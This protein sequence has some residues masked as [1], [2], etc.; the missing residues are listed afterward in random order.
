MQ[1]VWTFSEDPVQECDYYHYWSDNNRTAKSFR[2]HLWNE[3]VGNVLWEVVLSHCS[4]GNHLK[5]FLQQQEHKH[6]GELWVF[7]C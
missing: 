4:Y 1:S 3:G 6:L 5:S 2:P 7:E